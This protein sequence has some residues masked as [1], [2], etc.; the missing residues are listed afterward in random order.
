MPVFTRANIDVHIAKTGKRI[1]NKDQHSIPTALQKGK[2]F[3]DD[4]YLE[5]IRCACDENYFYVKAQCCHSFSKND[6]PHQLKIALNII[7]GNVEHAVCTCISGN[8]G[9]CNHMIGL[10]FKLCKFT[11]YKCTVTTDLS[12]EADQQATLAC[13]SK[14]QQ[15]HQKGGG[16]KIKPEPVMEMVIEKTKLNDT[17]TRSGVKCLLYEARRNCLHDMKAEQI[18][19]ATLSTTEPNC[20]FTHMSNVQVQESKETKYGKCPKG[21]Y[22]S[23]QVGYSEANFT[24][25]ADINTITR[26]ALPIAVNLVYPQL[27]LRNSDETLQ[28]PDGMSNDELSFLRGLEVDEKKINEIENESRE[29]ANSA[30]W[31]EERRWRFTA[32][33]FHTISK[34]QRNHDN[35]ADSLINPKEVKTVYTEH[36]KRYESTA[37]LEYHKFMFHQKTPV[38]VLPC[39]LVVSKDFPILGASPDSRVIDTGCVYHFGI[40]EVKCPYK[41][42]NVH[43]L[44]AADDS[45]FFME[46]ISDKQCKLKE[47][48]MY[49]SQV[50]GQMGIT[51][52][53]WC[54][55]IVYTKVG[56]YVQRISFDPDFWNQLRQ[57]LVSY[58]FNHFIHFA[59]KSYSEQQNDN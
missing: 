43:P 10:M 46:K 53:M 58:F 20:G 19:R 36:G 38:K 44:N 9:L 33:N 22:T 47:N 16:K 4:E 24:A 25:V 34:R 3:D 52:A 30:R 11:I 31:S 45:K 26:L 54:D 48:H 49:Y 57:Q 21:S 41:Y 27:P 29:Q 42:F 40:A 32:S 12:H 51:G 55:F 14:L 15:W 5:E 39:G 59:A 37:L 13:T 56:L 28:I 6:L 2:R 7:S 18:L 35:F 23:Y 8:A 17:K 50:Q 1:A